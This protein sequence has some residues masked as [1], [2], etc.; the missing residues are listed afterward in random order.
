MKRFSKTTV[1]EFILALA[2]TFLVSIAYSCFFVP[3]NIAPGGIGGL[4]VVLN[5]FIPIGVGT[6]TLLLNIPIFIFAMR[7]IGVKFISK[8]LVMLVFMSLCIDYLPIEIPLSDKFLAVVCGGVLMGV[9]LGVVMYTNTSTGGTDTLAMALSKK[10]PD[11]KSSEL[12]LILD[13]AVV[14]AAAFIN[15]IETGIYSA[16]AVFMQIIFIDSV[17]DGINSSRAVY[18]ITKKPDEMKQ[19]IYGEIKRG[20]TEVS[21]HGGFTGNTSR[22][23]LCIVSK[24]QVA[25]VKRCVKQTDPQAFMFD[26]HVQEVIGNGFNQFE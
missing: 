24:R 22:M 2:G 12:L 26:T 20:I 13:A 6:L 17:F 4:S 15:G 7:V 19:C 18:I 11:L 23:L 8:T 21:I 9:G 3:N 25:A 14:V 5:Q 10:F 16:V 1:R